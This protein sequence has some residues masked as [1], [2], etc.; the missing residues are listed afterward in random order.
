MKYIMNVLM[1]L[2]LFVGINM[3]TP[4]YSIGILAE[5]SQD[6]NQ[7]NPQFESIGI[8]RK[9][10]SASTYE[11]IINFVFGNYWSPQPFR[12]NLDTSTIALKIKIKGPNDPT[13]TITWDQNWIGEIWC[14]DIGSEITT[15]MQL[16]ATFN[17]NTEYVNIPRQKIYNQ[18]QVAIRIKGKKP[19]G[20]EV[21]YDTFYTG[22]S[23]LDSE[24]TNNIPPD[25][26]DS[27][28]EALQTGIDMPCYVNN[29]SISSVLYSKDANAGE[30]QTFLSKGTCNWSV[31]TNASDWIE[32][33]G[34]NIRTGNSTVQY[35]IKENTTD[36]VRYGN[37]YADKQT[38]TIV[39]KGKAPQPV[40]IITEVIKEVPV[41]VIKEVT[42]EIP[43]EVIKEVP[44]PLPSLLTGIVVNVNS[45][46]RN[47]DSSIL[48]VV[49]LNSKDPL[50]YSSQETTQ[51][52][53][54]GW[55]RN[56]NFELAN[57]KRNR[58]LNP[59]NLNT[60][61]NW[62]KIAA[63]IGFVVGIDQSNK[64]FGWGQNS[65]GQLGT[66]DKVARSSPTSINS[67]I[68]WK[69]V[70]AGS[71]H[72]I[73]ISSNGELY[74]S[75]KNTNG[76]LGTGN[77]I[78]F[79]NL[80]KIGSK[81][82][83]VSV[84]AS[85]DQSYAIDSQ[86]DLYAWGYNNFGQLGVGRNDVNINTPTKVSGNMKWKKI[87]S[88]E[89]HA[90]ALTTTNELYSWGRNSTGQ[91]GIGTTNSNKNPNPIK[92]GTQ[93]WS[94][95]DCGNSFSGA[96]NS[97][98][99]LFVWGQNNFGQLGLGNST[100]RPQPTKVN[101]GPVNKICFGAFHSF[102]ILQNKQVYCWGRNNEGQL[103]L[104]SNSPSVYN[105][106]ILNN[107][108]Q[109]ISNIICGEYSTYAMIS[110]QQNTGENNQVVFENQ[111]VIF[112][113]VNSS[114][115][116]SWMGQSLQD[117]EIKIVAKLESGTSLINETY[118]SNVLNSSSITIASQQYREIIVEAILYKNQNII[119]KIETKF[120]VKGFQLN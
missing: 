49:N 30:F 24:N 86:G 71:G 61:E 43:I 21:V 93:T 110:V 78:S 88:G 9:P 47:I 82:D 55:G 51:G 77:F 40:E 66:G 34:S 105:S 102:V 33:L 46:E 57:D 76:Q 3:N 92:I 79:V 41:E 26:A 75:G 87:S 42:V 39:Q 12:V 68:Q 22:L 101:I 53:L 31:S 111:S 108:L 45:T 70:S 83:W 64:L 98:G 50:V 115:S 65:F 35:K 85:A 37:I 19:D 103:G 18:T 2:I 89:F 112:V 59:L 56:F 8:F 4:V 28:F 84:K 118:Q 63:G 91:L 72:I 7:W 29:L 73:A 23:A 27:F 10:N 1:G 80:Q 16:V 94:D 81:S 20:S 90:I 100:T 74:A 38:F 109:D 97:A 67:S 69:D 44:I 116:F 99:E 17:K 11:N 104:G 114:I 25:E 60:N 48:K 6:S 106:P 58:E 96:I 13:G 15:P 107:R 62:I 120:L 32:I 52:N 113:P 119:N 95:I 14:S 36:Q 54:L 5:P 117:H